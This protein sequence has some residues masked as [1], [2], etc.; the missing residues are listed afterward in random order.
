MPTD[1]P[2]QFK[3]AAKSV[4]GVVADENDIAVGEWAWIDRTTELEQDGAKAAK[5][6]IL[7]YLRDPDCKTL[8]TLWYRFGDGKPIGHDID[9]QGNVWP[10]VHHK[11]PYGDP[12]VEQCGFHTHPTKLL[13]FVDLR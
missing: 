3:R 9:G 11:W 13:D 10:S 7:I 8:C 12:P 1:G 4:D 5:R 6:T 2:Y